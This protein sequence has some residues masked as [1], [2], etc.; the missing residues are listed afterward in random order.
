[1]PT[2]TDGLTSFA[3]TTLYLIE[4]DKKKSEEIT[5]IEQKIMDKLLR[6]M[7]V[8]KEMS[9]SALT[10][11]VAPDYRGMVVGVLAKM[12]KRGLVKMLYERKARNGRPT[13]VWRLLDGCAN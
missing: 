3:K 6:V 8:R 2:T 9:R 4:V 5:E 1:M 13:Q 12:E 7:S 11:Q 10:K